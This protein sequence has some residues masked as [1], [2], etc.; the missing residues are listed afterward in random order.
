M[1]FKKVISDNEQKVLVKGTCGKMK[2]VIAN[3]RFF[4]AGG[5]EK[6]MFKFMEAATQ[7]G[8]EVIPFSVS[9]PQ[10]QHTP[11]EKYFARPRASS[12]M[13]ADTKWT[14]RNIAGM[15]RATVWNFDAEYRLR[16][17]IKNTN[18]DAVYILHEINHLSPSIISAANKERVRVVHRIS[19]FFM[20]CPRSDFLCENETCESCLHGQ[21]KKAIQKKCVKGSLPGTFLRI[22]AMLLYKKLKIFDKVGHYITTCNF[23]REKCIEGGIDSRKITCIPTFID[24]DQVEPCYEN[25]KYFL[26]LG[27]TT[28]Q[29][30]VIYAVKAMKRLRDTEYVLK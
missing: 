18:P 4:V 25:D 7:M 23:T 15:V 5:P 20:F 2:I 17:L 10:N 6:Y 11:Y 1:C 3:Y 16:K 27:R 22:I 14:L 19:D 12:L 24:T 29:K 9:N 26:F 28:Y 21:Y 30:G 8:V 13:Y